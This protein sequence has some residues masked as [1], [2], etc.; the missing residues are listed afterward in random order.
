MNALRTTGL[1]AAVSLPWKCILVTYEAKAKSCLMLLVRS[2]H[3]LSEILLIELVEL[4][5]EYNVRE[6]RNWYRIIFLFTMLPIS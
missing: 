6:Q 3:I 5:A 1:H 2:L 4:A